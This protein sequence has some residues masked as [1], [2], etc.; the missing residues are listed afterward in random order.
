MYYDEIK[1]PSYVYQFFNIRNISYRSQFIKSLPV[2]SNKIHQHKTTIKLYAQ[3]HFTKV[4]VKMLV[5][6]NN[7]FFTNQYQRFDLMWKN[8]QSAIGN[9]TMK[10]HLSF[11]IF[12][13][14]NH[15]RRKTVWNFRDCPSLINTIYLIILIVILLLFP[16]SFKKRTL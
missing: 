12:L 4:K 1:F 13:V 14:H 9:K 2:L 7:I 6:K 8:F 16:L 5:M 3:C 15:M 10:L 11:N